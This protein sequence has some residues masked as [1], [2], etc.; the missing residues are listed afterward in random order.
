VIFQCAFW[1]LA[2]GTTL[3][4]LGFLLLGFGVPGGHELRPLASEVIKFGLAQAVPAIL[5][6][7][8]I[9]FRKF[10]AFKELPAKSW[11]FPIGGWPTQ[12]IWLEIL[13]FSLASLVYAAVVCRRYE[14]GM[15]LM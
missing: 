1:A 7:I 3:S 8:G 9:A 14:L 2:I 12:L 4:G 13:A 5:L 10:E 15:F 11:I 6:W